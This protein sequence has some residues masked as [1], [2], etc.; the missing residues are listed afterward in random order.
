[1]RKPR[2]TKSEKAF[3]ERVNAIVFNPAMIRDGKR[4]MNTNT[5]HALPEDAQK[6]YM[7]LLLN[8]TR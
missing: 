5:F 7:N 8:K 2:M 6:R 4:Y 3:M 1:M